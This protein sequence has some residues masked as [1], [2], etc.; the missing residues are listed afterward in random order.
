MIK[1]TSRHTVENSYF[2]LHKEN[3]KKRPGQHD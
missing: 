3:E 1:E 2:I